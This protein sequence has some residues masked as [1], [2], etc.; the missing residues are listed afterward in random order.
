MPEQDAVL[1]ITA[2]TTDT[3][4]IM[5]HVWNHLLAAMKSSPLPVDRAAEDA[6]LSRTMPLAFKVPVGE[7][8]SPMANS[9]SGRTYRFAP[10]D[11]GFESVTLRFDDKGTAIEYGK[12][13][14]AYPVSSVP[15]EWTT[16]EAAVGPRGHSRYFCYAVWPDPAT[17]E[18]TL[19]FYETPFVYT[20]VFQ[21][22]GDLVRFTCRKNVSFGPIEQTI[23]GR[24]TRDA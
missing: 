7:C 6:L 18:V 4:R 14:V 17:Y 8:G 10:N 19:C 3:D 12:N 2:A 16:G 11:E 21:F 24:G 15:L 22:D 13:G 1:A 23:E 5:E 9:I 20:H